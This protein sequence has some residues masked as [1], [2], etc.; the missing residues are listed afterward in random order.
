MNIKFAAGIL[1]VALLVSGCI[2]KEISFS[3]P[4]FQENEMK[5]SLSVKFGETFRFEL[6][7]NP[8][9]GFEWFEQHDPA[10]LE[11]VSRKF[12]PSSHTRLVGSSGTQIFI[13]K[14]TAKGETTIEL[15]YKRQWEKNV[16]PT[17]RVLCRVKVN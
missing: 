1:F 14:A 16:P 3:I 2:Q 12:L 17:K 13:F 4:I 7:S 6:E 15:V 11:L 8:S 10:I 5:T 9:T